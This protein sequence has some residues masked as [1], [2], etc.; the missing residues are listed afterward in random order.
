MDTTEEKFCELIALSESNYTEYYSCKN[1]ESLSTNCQTVFQHQHFKIYECTKRDD[2]VIPEN[3]NPS[4]P[5]TENAKNAT[6]NVTRNITK[7]VTKTYPSINK[8]KEL[9]KDPTI[10]INSTTPEKNTSYNNKTLINFT[11]YT[12]QD[13]Q[14][15]HDNIQTVDVKFYLNIFS[16]LFVSFIMC[17]LCACY[18]QY[19]CERCKNVRQLKR[20]RSSRTIS[21]EAIVVDVN[22][23]EEVKEETKADEPIRPPKPNLIEEEI[24]I[25]IQTMIRKVELN[26]LRE[27]KQLLRRRR[28][29]ERNAK[30]KHRIKQKPPAPNASLAKLALYN[31]MRQKQLRANGQVKLEPMQVHN[32]PKRGMLIKEIT[33]K[34]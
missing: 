14:K 12:V 19:K 27:R 20:T 4:N 31:L 23:K 32:A 7:N 28:R 9:E 25:I 3:N 1:N 29:I 6:E 33:K 10:K 17:A 8:T 15:H 11:N 2:N 5:K 21:P 18:I 24:K 34:V 30:L 22:E 16:I 13:L 26:I